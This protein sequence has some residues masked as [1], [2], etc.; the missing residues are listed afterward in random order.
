MSHLHRLNSS[1]H[2]KAA[3]YLYARAWR[4][5]RSR[6]DLAAR[7]VVGSSM[8]AAGQALLAAAAG[9]LARSLAQAPGSLISLRPIGIALR[10][11]HGDALL[12]IAVIGAAAALFKLVGG[13]LA[14]SA[15]ARLSG[16]LAADLRLRVLGNVLAGSQGS[17]PIESGLASLT[18]HVQEVER[19]VTLGVFGELRAVLQLA[20]LAVLLA[21]LAPRLAAGATLALLAFAL[22]VLFA[23]RAQK[24]A[25]ANA[26]IESEMLLGA[27]NE[28]V[29]HADL[30]TTYGAE[31]RIICHVKALGRT[32]IETAARLRTR[33]ALLS[34]T[35]EVA[36][37]FALVLVLLLA[38]AGMIDG[39]TRAA[40]VPFAIVFFMTYRPL[41]ELV[42]ARLVRVRAEQALARMIHDV[43]GTTCAPP[44]SPPA[45]A[46][47]QR[48]WQRKILRLEGVVTLHGR[49][50]PVSFELAPGSIAVLC[51]PT[52]IG[53]T[54][55][56]RTLL[57]LEEACAGSVHWGN[58]DLT[59]DGVG[60]SARPFAWVP[61]D[62]PILADTLDANIMLG[63]AASQST[64]DSLAM[65]AMIGAGELAA[66]LGNAVLTPPLAISGGER[67]WIAVARALATSL[68]VLLLDEPTSFLDP[69][70]QNKMLEALSALRGKRTIILVT[71]RPEPLSI[72][73]VVVQLGPL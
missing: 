61:Q 4:T 64:D 36:G 60:P 12:G 8:H 63:G 44:P 16:R 49:H 7:F 35:S 28:A 51:G 6:P 15:E 34:A 54:T 40:I 13:A 53:K 41:R 43:M 31:S 11:G 3:Q 37:A 48:V 46:T 57:G 33:T 59:N 29:K 23:R 19:G 47:A 52:G 73:D 45:P 62:A 5:A 56:L 1:Q 25:F 58:E 67:Q 42:E 10:A 68:P 71:H 72:A 22:L 65:L 9:F 38:R 70:S 30:W 69:A 55:L 39:D 17:R 66:S 32:M 14:A 26:A 20:P 50:A 24:R 18:M 21:L 27:A 2:P